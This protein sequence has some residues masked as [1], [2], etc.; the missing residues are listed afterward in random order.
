VEELFRNLTEANDRN[1]G[2]L[3]RALIMDT[4]LQQLEGDILEYQAA[5]R[6]ADA[7]TAAAYTRIAELE[8][9]R[10]R[11]AAAAGRTDELTSLLAA[12][13]RRQDELGWEVR[14][15]QAKLDVVSKDL[16]I[17]NQQLHMSASV[18]AEREALL[19]IQQAQLQESVAA[20]AASTAM[21]F[22]ASSSPHSLS[23]LLHPNP[24]VDSRKSRDSHSLS[25]EVIVHRIAKA[26]KLRAG[27]AIAL[28]RSYVVFQQRTVQSS[29]I[30]LIAQQLAS[31]NL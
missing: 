25:L 28:W 23:S 2:M 9:A 16:N 6:S 29:Q 8:E 14:R 17:V 30:T 10:Q 18:D 12:S 27:Y 31:L 21:P 1:E 13:E 19:N 26:A 7:K 15:G 5:C 20:A 22:V 11:D 3:S 4:R 24:G